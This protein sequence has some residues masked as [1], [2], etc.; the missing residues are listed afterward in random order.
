MLVIGLAACGEDNQGESD[1]GT[2]EGDA[3]QCQGLDDFSPCEVT[4]E[5]DRDFDICVNEKCV[6]PGCGLIE[7]NTPGPHFAMPDTGLGKC[8][9]YDIGELAE[10]LG[11][12]DTFT[13]ETTPYCGQ[14]AQYGL[15]LTVEPEDRFCRNTDLA[16][17][18]VEDLHTGLIWT[19]CLLGASGENCDQDDPL[20]TS[21]TESLAACDALDHGGFDD[22]R[23]PDRWE[24]MSI[25]DYGNNIPSVN[26]TFFPGIPNPCRAWSSTLQ[27]E[28]GTSWTVELSIGWSMFR[29]I[30]EEHPAFC[31]RG[32]PE[33]RE[34]Q[35]LSTQDETLV[36]ADDVVVEQVSSLEW[37]R[38]MAGTSGDDC[39]EGEAVSM[40]WHEALAYCQGLLLDGEDNW[41]LPNIKEISAL[42]EYRY[43]P[44]DFCVNTDVFPNTPENGW[45]WSSTPSVRGFDEVWLLAS[46]GAI[47]GAGI[48]E[49][50]SYYARCVRNN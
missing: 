11:S 7:C 10:C 2:D 50:S 35:F 47:E 46:F 17:S 34:H 24:L 15:D 5:P 6:S 20:E 36:P 28:I 25:L 39:L 19:G 21:W 49:S 26:A 18:T 32:T 14:D 4:T 44:D 23:L 41:R 30:D 1:G 13:C 31:V 16:D 12:P 3:S 27:S 37:Q 8:Y 9:D 40:E 29:V 33:P 45:F 42:I 22:W 43:Q 38:C 48:M